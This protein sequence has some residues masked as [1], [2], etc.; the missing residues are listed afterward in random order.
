MDLYDD[1]YSKLNWKMCIMY[2]NIEQSSCFWRRTLLFLLQC[3]AV[4]QKSG[5]KLISGDKQARFE[6]FFWQ[7]LDSWSCGAETPERGKWS[8]GALVEG[9]GTCW[10]RVHH[11]PPRFWEA[12]GP[13]VTPKLLWQSR[14][15][16]RLPDEIY[17]AAS[18]SCQA[19]CH[20]QSQPINTPV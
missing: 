9:W 17:W 18:D 10:A 1:G 8:D 16:A 4:K 15:A 7:V 11:L 19:P 13:W 2:N 3:E 5:V 6:G 20:H 14:Q 12:H